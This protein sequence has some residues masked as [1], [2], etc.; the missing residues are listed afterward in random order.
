LQ[1]LLDA[2]PAD[3]TVACLPTHDSLILHDGE[4]E[5]GSIPLDGVVD[6]SLLVDSSTRRRY[7]I[8]RSL[9]LGPL[10]LLFPKRAIHETYR[11]CIEWK[12]L[13]SD[14]HFTYIRI[15]RRVLADNM[16]GTIK[17]S[18]TPEVRRELA[19][20]VSMTKECTVVSERDQYPTDIWPFIT[21]RFCTM[22][23]RKA[24]LP[25][26]SKCPVCGRPLNVD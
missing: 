3:R 13:K 5:F 14:Y 24:D 9:L 12:D 23:F 10:V 25:L 19:R 7:P 11:I 26:G 1:D 22:E 4:K 17:R 16:L 2:V 18:L 6:V 8:G 15:S 20:K 21:C